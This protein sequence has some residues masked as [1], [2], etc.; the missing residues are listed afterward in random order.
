MKT[1]SLTSKGLSA[2]G[3][4]HIG[5]FENVVKI[6]PNNKAWD[7]YLLIFTFYDSNSARLAEVIMPSH[8]NNNPVCS[9]KTDGYVLVKK[10]ADNCVYVTSV[11]NSN[12]KIGVS[13]IGKTGNKG[14]TIS[15]I[16]KSEYEEIST[17]D[18]AMI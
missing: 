2:E 13:C 9:R 11:A 17:T 12:Y 4:C 8:K 7:R 1:A 18:V 14:I 3:F 5:I 15:N 6:S 16:S 10:D